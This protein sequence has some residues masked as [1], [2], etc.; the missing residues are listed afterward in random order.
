MS[1]G[2]SGKCIRDVVCTG[3]GALMVRDSRRKGTQCKACADHARYNPPKP[4][5]GCGTML[6]HDKRRS[7]TM[8]RACVEAKKRLPDRHCEECGVLL[9]RRSETTTTLCRTHAAKSEGRRA[10]LRASMQIVHADP[11]YQ[12]RRGRAQS[13]AR[14]AHI[15]LA[16]REDYRRLMYSQRYHAKDCARI[17]LDQAAAAVR[18][19]NKKFEQE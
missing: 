3:C 14:L 5:T 7:G 6:K 13:A 18:R 2:P 10:K 19:H 1:S 12:K 8:C 11:E 4:C 17:V 15:P 9:S 16:Y